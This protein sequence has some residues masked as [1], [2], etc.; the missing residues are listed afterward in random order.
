MKTRAMM[1]TLFIA[2]FFF[3]ACENSIRSKIVDSDKPAND[4]DAADDSSA[5]DDTPLIDDSDEAAPDTVED[6]DTARPDGDTIDSVCV[7]HWDCSEGMFCKRPIDACDEPGVCAILPPACDESWAPVC[8]C[9]GMTYSNECTANAGS[10]NVAYAGECQAG[11]ICVDTTDCDPGSYCLTP[12]GMC[13][14]EGTCTPYP[15]AECADTADIVCGCDGSAYTN[16]CFAQEKGVSIAHWG[17]CGTMVSC[18]ANKQCTET[19]YCAKDIGDCDETTKGRCDLR[20]IGCEEIS[21]LILVCGCNGITY[22]HPCFAYNGGTNIS[23]EGACEGENICLNNDDCEPTEFCKKVLGLCDTGSGVCEPRPETCPLAAPITEPVCGCDGLDYSDEC[24]ANTAGMNIAS[25]GSCADAIPKSSLTYSYRAD[26][27]PQ[28][29]A[30]IL[31]AR[32]AEE[33]L[34]Y[35][36]ATVV[37]KVSTGISN[38][39][40]RVTYGYTTPAPGQENIIVQLALPRTSEVPYAVQIDGGESYV[41]WLDAM[42]NTKIEFIGTV[43]ITLYETGD[44]PNYTITALDFFGEGLVPKP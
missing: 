4:S 15:D 29:T 7:E 2:A 10:H 21:A 13:G 26:G 9:D 17:P 11:K 18:T 37:E 22:D 28:V 12:T 41:R 33:T 16:Y 39:F 19:E 31:V 38:I 23:H 32:S 8:G 25:T 44:F 24:N 36:E 1:T 43:S 42:G 6:I 3:T 40:L 14:G 35:N 5:L 34:E 27:T 20:P 30:H